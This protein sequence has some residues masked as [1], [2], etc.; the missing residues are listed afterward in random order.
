MSRPT[1]QLPSGD[2]LVGAGLPIIGKLLHRTQVQTTA[3]YAH[4]ANDPVKSA[5]IRSA[6]ASPKWRRPSQ[7]DPDKPLRRR[8]SWRRCLRAQD[9]LWSRPLDLSWQGW[10]SADHT[11]WGAGPRDASGRT[12]RPHRASGK[13]TGGAN[14]R[15]VEGPSTETERSVLSGFWQIWPTFTTTGAE[16]DEAWTGTRPSG[17]W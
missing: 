13:S 3:C 11:S 8:G 10:R 5:P 4:P 1:T 14:D 2:L 15:R 6:A 12:P 17:A 9:R 16:I 7:S